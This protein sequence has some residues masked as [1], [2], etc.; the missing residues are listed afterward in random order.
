[1]TTA[2]LEQTEQQTQIEKETQKPTAEEQ[3]A[4][5]QA[6]S[7]SFNAGVSRVR[8]VPDV[9]K[10]E[11]V[12]EQPAATEAETTTDTT[13]AAAQTADA[14]KPVL[15]GLTESEI[16]AALAQL[17]QLRDRAEKTEQELR[18]VFGRFGDI[19]S[20]LTATAAPGKVNAEALKKFKDEYPDMAE[21]I[22]P[23]LIGLPSAGPGITQEQV[24]AHVNK[25]V[26]EG[27]STAVRELNAE[28]LG[29]F[30][31]DWE[32]IRESD[33]LQLWLGTQ[34]PAYREK[35]LGSS[36][37]VFL[38]NGIDK[39]K[40]WKGNSESTRQQSTSRLERAI[41][42]KGRSAP[43]APAVSDQAAFNRGFNRVRGG[44]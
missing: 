19:Q 4:L 8:G 18:K 25:A 11:E 27:V 36:S 12:T 39:F 43:G 26:A 3:A 22:E 6:A 20:K 34:A 7:D 31:S 23:L 37:A 42:P 17:P 14:E 33:D 21:L 40:A 2:E 24:D 29:R 32:T 9:P 30:H 10:K 35:F 13:A 1:M 41:A 15:A 16:K 44:G 38:A 28:M 5:D